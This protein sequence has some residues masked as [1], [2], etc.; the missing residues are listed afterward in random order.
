MIGYQDSFDGASLEDLISTAMCFGD[1]CGGSTT[2]D[3]SQADM[4]T[5]PELFATNDPE[6]SDFHTSDFHTSYN[7]TV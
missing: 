5:D 7:M 3:W 2:S 6:S 1:V 4:E